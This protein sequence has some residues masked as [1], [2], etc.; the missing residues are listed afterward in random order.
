M[1]HRTAWRAERRWA[2][3]VAESSAHR[4]LGGVS[5][6]PAHESVPIRRARVL[7]R[8]CAC[9]CAQGGVCVG[10]V[11]A[12]GS[13]RVGVGVGVGVDVGVGVGVL[14]PATAR[15]SVWVSQGWLE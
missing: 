4:A 11:Q 5:P 14:V 9:P 10:G 2:P 13:E 15:A 3:D 7:A 8:A 6:A 1:M 12:D